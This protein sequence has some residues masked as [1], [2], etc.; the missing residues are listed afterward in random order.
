M[1][2]KRELIRELTNSAWSILASYERDERNG[3]FTR[4]QAQAQAITRVE[5]LRYGEEGKDYFWIQ[6]LQ[7][8]MVMHPYRSGS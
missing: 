6:D 8:R 7:P 2:R 1:E 5:A 4:E 3:L